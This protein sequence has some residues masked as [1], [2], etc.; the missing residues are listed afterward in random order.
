ME[1]GAGL[2]ATAVFPAH[3]AA[4]YVVGNAGCANE[5]CDVISSYMQDLCEWGAGQLAKDIL[6]QMVEHIGEACGSHIVAVVA[7]LL[8]FVVVFYV[9][10]VPF[11]MLLWW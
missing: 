11:S 9:I 4:A 3:K 8:A 6:L 2:F 1:E 5:G 10:L 7:G